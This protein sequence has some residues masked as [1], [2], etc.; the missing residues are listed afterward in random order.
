[1]THKIAA[2]HPFS[3]GTCQKDVLASH[4]KAEVSRSVGLI[5]IDGKPEGTGFRVGDKYIMTCKHVVTKVIS[6][7]FLYCYSYKCSSGSCVSDFV[8]TLLQ[9]TTLIDVYALYASITCLCKSLQ[10]KHTIKKKKCLL[11]A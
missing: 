9:S 8:N 4:A 6:G 11:S 5:Y 10:S 2:A 7:T 1:M 3:K